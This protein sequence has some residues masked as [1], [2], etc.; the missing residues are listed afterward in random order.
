MKESEVFLRPP[1]DTDKKKTANKCRLAIRICDDHVALV[2]SS[3]NKLAGSLEN[4]ED[5]TD[6][7]DAQF[8]KFMNRAHSIIMMLHGRKKDLLYTLNDL[9]ESLEYDQEGQQETRPMNFLS[10]SKLPP[11]PIPTFSGKRWEWENFW[12]LFK[13]NVHEQDLTNLQKF[14]Y[15]LSSLTGEAKQSISKFQVSADN[16]K[17]ALEHLKKRYGQ[18]DGII[19]DLHMALKSCVAR[20]PRTEDQRQLLEKVSAIAIQL[21]QKGEHID[22]H[23]TIHTFLQKFHV[24]IQ[25]AAMERRLQREATHGTAEPEWTLS[26]WLEAIEGVISQEEKLKEMLTDDLEKVETQQQPNR[27]RGRTQNSVCCENCRQKGHKW[28]V[29]PRLPT[30]SAKKN[31]LIETNRC[32]NCGSSMHRVSSCSSGYCRICQGKHHTAICTKSTPRSPQQQSDIPKKGTT[33]PEPMRPP[34]K[35]TQKEPP[36]QKPA[37]SSKQHS[38]VTGPDP[39]ATMIEQ[40]TI[41][42]QTYRQPRG[43]DTT[44]NKVVLLVGSAQVLDAKNRLREAIVLLD[45]GSELS[46]ICDKLADELDLPVVNNTTLTIGTFGSPKSYTRECEITTLRLCDIEGIQHELQLHRSQYITGTVEQADLNEED[47]EFISNHGLTL[48]MPERLSSVQPQILL[49]CNYLW[50]FMLPLGKMTLPSGLQ[51]IPTK[52][53]YI[54]SG[55]Q[56]LEAHTS[57]KTLVVCGTEEEKETWDR[58]WALEATGTDEFTGPEKSERQQINEKVLQ[59][60]RSTI[61]R[62]DDGYYVRLPWKS[63]CTT[64]PDNKSIALKRLYKVLETYLHD[65][66]TLLQYDAIF[67]EQFEKGVIEKVPQEE[68]LEGTVVH[69]LPH[70]AVITPSKQTTK[71]RIVFDASAHYKDKPCLNDVL[72]QGPLL[73]PDMVSILLRFRA[74]NI[75]IISVVEKAFLQVRLQEEDRDATRCM[76]VRDIS[77]PPT[78][79]NIVTYRFT[80]VTFGLNTSPFLLASTI[81]F[82]LDHMTSSSDMAKELKENLYV[83]NLIIGAENL[84]DALSKYYVAKDVFKGLNMN[85]REFWSNDSVFN[86]TIPCED[87]SQTDNPKVLGLQ[88][89]PQHDKLI[90]K[91]A[92]N[93]CGIVTRRTVSR[94]LASVYDPLGF[95]VPILLPAKVFLQSLWKD[96]Y[97]WDTPLSPALKEQWIIISQGITTFYKELERQVIPCKGSSTMFVFADA[98][99]IAMAACAYLGS[100]SSIKL[101]MAKSKLPSLKTAITIP[102][103]EMNALTLATRLV[104]FLHPCTHIYVYIYLRISTSGHTSLSPLVDIRKILLFTDSEIVLGW[105]RVPPDRKNIGVLVTNRLKEIKKIVTNLDTKGVTCLF[106]HVSTKDNPADCG[107]RGFTLATCEEHVWWEGPEMIHKDILQTSECMFQIPTQDGEEPDE[108][109]NPMVVA[110]LFKERDQLDNLT[111]FDLSRFS[112]LHK[113]QRVAAYALRFI[114]RSLDRFKADRKEAIFNTIPA[115]KVAASKHELSG[116]EL[117]EARKCIIR[118][119]QHALVETNTIPLQKELNIQPDEDG[120]LRCYGRLKHAAIPP[121]AQTPIFVAPKTAL[122]RIIIWEAHSQYH[123]GVA[124]TMS[125][126]RERYWIPKLRQQ[127]AQLL[128]KCFPC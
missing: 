84:E 80:R 124:H 94:Q 127:V 109:E 58:Y 39:A 44:R 92:L 41:V 35:H 126:V 98:S 101:V 71:M 74:H 7:D 21:K 49:G 6:V 8:D 9:L 50:E 65:R 64:L 104:H 116:L 16:Y 5:R 118:D 36:K 128:R 62:R 10:V 47:L 72:H 120:I 83:D 105:L 11:I 55:R 76:W 37:K 115:L 42:L 119:H 59:D 68:P 77:L 90:I 102:K 38:V 4:L 121:S 91:G 97:D 40:G 54:V 57:T 43:S 79:E 106:G 67:K 117:R 23:L 22:T 33:P 96:E 93:P 60:F 56:S 17:Q 99:H 15:L 27:V 122:A 12:A 85:L 14:N 20:S 86:Y 48:S 89:N 81:A 26:Q 51:L 113:A 114:R 25:K 78:K 2:E 13:E 45:T 100:P 61:Q 82:H 75:A 108:V 111:T 70:Q 107:R 31:F 123:L 103:L 34:Q 18:K 66:D 28:N 110:T 63:S 52:F 125:A 87:R 30:P 1:Q 112:T 88:W 46:F 19:R 32:L 73:L 3:L 95:L 24:R 53:G 29:C 69:Y